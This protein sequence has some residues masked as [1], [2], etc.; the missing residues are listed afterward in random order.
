MEMKI[1]M[2]SKISQMQTNVA[3]ILSQVDLDPNQTDRKTES[4]CNRGLFDEMTSKGS[5]CPP[6]TLK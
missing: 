2:L 4:K 3:H 5:H 6:H 1:I